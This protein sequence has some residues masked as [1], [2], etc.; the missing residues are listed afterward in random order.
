[1]NFRV[2]S[3]RPAGPKLRQFQTKAVT[4]PASRSTAAYHN[5]AQA[6][7]ASRMSVGEKLQRLHRPLGAPTAA[8]SIAVQ[9]GTDLRSGAKQVRYHD[10]AIERG[11]GAHG[12]TV[13]G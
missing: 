2:R 13:L 5:P 3:G 8:Q 9:H 6:W 7:P 10:L 4:D 1:M 12:G 11:G